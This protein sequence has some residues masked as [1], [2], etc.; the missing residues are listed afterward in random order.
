MKSGVG[1]FYGSF[2]KCFRLSWRKANGNIFWAEM[3]SELHQK[4]LDH[5][6]LLKSFL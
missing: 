5:L 1:Y 2:L 6:S 3:F 4:R